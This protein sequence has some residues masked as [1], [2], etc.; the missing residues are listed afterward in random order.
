MSLANWD[1]NRIYTT[2]KL[3]S[4]RAWKP[5]LNIN[6]YNILL[7]NHPLCSIM[8][9]MECFYDLYPKVMLVTKKGVP[10][11]TSEKTLKCF[12]HVRSWLSCLLQS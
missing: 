11:G 1:K 5:S 9:A 12:Y 8:S 2:L 4:I 3:S 7:A 6:E 10:L